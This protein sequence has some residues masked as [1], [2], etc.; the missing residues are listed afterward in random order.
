MVF[1]EVEEQK[2][3]LSIEN[4]F[5]HLSAAEGDAK[6]PAETETIAEKDSPSDVI[7]PIPLESKKKKPRILIIGA[8]MAGLCAARELQ[9]RGYQ[10]LV[11][12]ARH[13]PGG[14]LKTVAMVDE[15]NDK[16]EEEGASKDM[17]V[18]GALIHGIVDN[19]LYEMVQDD[20]EHSTRP[21]SD[22][23]L[24]SGETGWPIDVALDERVLQSFNDCL[25]ETFA[26]IDAQHSEQ[27]SFGA[28][29]QRICQERHVNLQQ[30][31]FQWHKANLELSC[32]APFHNLGLDWNDDEPFGFDGA[33]V[34]LSKSWKPVC[35]SLA[36]SL[37]ILYNAPVRRIHIV[38]PSSPPSADVADP[39]LNNDDNQQP[40]RTRDEKV[41]SIHQTTPAASLTPTARRTVVKRNPA[42]SSS[43]SP[44][45][46][47][48]RL[49]GEDTSDVR[50]SERANKGVPVPP[51]LPSRPPT[52]SKHRN[53]RKRPT[54]TS[55][56]VVQVTMQ[57]GITWEVDAVVC[58]IPLGVLKDGSVTFDPPLPKDKQSA[59]Q[60]L[61]TGLL[62]KCVLTFAKRFWQ[63]S[64]FL[65]LADASHSYLVLNAAKYTTKPVLL[66]MY[67]GSF[68]KEMEDWTDAAVVEDCLLVLRRMCG[69]DSVTPPLD[70]H[71]TRWGQ[72][73]YARMSFTY[74]PPGVS[75]HDTLS[76]MRQPIFDHT[77]RFP[78]LM[79]AGEHTTPYHPSTIHGAYFSGIREAYRWDCA[80]DP[81]AIHGLEYSEEHIYQRTFVVKPPLRGS[82]AKVKSPAPRN[83]ASL[84]P[85]PISYRRGVNG[86]MTLRRR[87]KSY[88]QINSSHRTNGHAVGGARHQG[89]LPAVVGYTGPG[90]RQSPRRTMAPASALVNGS[91]IATD[92]HPPLD[93]SSKGR[94][95]RISRE[96]RLPL[97]QRILWR[98]VE[99]FGPNF[100]YIERMVFPV[101]ESVTTKSSFKDSRQ[102]ERRGRKFLEQRDRSLAQR[103]K[104]IRFWYKS[105]LAAEVA[106]PYKDSTN[107]ALTGTVVLSR[108]R[109]SS[110]I[111]S[112]EV[113]TARRKIEGTPMSVTTRFGRTT[114]PPP[115]M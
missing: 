6:L 101:H 66:F 69:R 18:G 57:S 99:S 63:N 67:G 100:G 70:Y 40:S 3:E 50:R 77:G 87:P 42:V 72:D 9:Q 75:A 94:S 38:H 113:T 78:V 81:G 21:L 32:G 4:G 17:D 25:A 28:L 22:C 44:T 92:E 86:E 30:A 8:G 82:G 16:E 110:M 93:P 108:K 2:E 37:Y 53:H 31:L 11:V 73:P 115:P 95:K 59:I 109:N 29:F 33:H 97:E 39:M 107:G 105:W 71:V 65:G 98:S 26:R 27:V 83:Q 85:P 79:F 20:M 49:R 52:T 41:R 74:V 90:V 48:R 34:A 15:E 51:T 80:W 84:A 89:T 76:A 114:K 68:A 5:H 106:P 55:S 60:S 46:R 103:Q 43:I 47:S 24:L 45:R 96:R 91:N 111:A 58:T 61:G 35:D 1:E 36:S 102:M 54:E 19:P 88:I 62:N 112:D 23:L 56:T 10:T 64:D 7:D 13:R 12:E 104:M 14:R